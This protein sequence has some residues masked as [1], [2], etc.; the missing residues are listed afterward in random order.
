[1]AVFIFPKNGLLVK[2]SDLSNSLT[3]MNGYYFVYIM[4]NEMDTVLYTGVTNNLKKRVYQHKEKLTDGFTKKYDLK[5]LVYYEVLEDAY[6]AI[7]REKKIKA[8]SRHKKIELIQKMNPKR[9][10]LY[11]DI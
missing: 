1:M 4:S 11:Q 3:F 9:K 8:G 10:D 6:N 7:A 2:L 5:K